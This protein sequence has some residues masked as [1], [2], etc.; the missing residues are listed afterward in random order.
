MRCHVARIVSMQSTRICNL[1]TSRQ[2]QGGFRRPMEMEGSEVGAKALHFFGSDQELPPARFPMQRFYE[3]LQK[4]VW[5]WGFFFLKK[6]TTSFCG[7][8]SF[9]TRPM[10][11]RNRRSMLLSPEAY[12]IGS[13]RSLNNERGDI[14]VTWLVLI[15]RFFPEV[16][17][18]MSKGASA[19][20]YVPWDLLVFNIF[21]F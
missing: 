21:F 1:R 12:G 4:L 15:P 2:K 8:S 9:E 18:C 3:W 17:P 19:S 10:K 6:S 7:I 16:C 5:I 11:K 14:A 20:W 13:D